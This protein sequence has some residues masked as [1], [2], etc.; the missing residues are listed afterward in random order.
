PQYFENPNMPALTFLNVAS[1]Q[2]SFDDL[3]PFVNVDTF[4]YVPQQPFWVEDLTVEEGDSIRMVRIDP[5]ITNNTYI[6]YKNGVAIDTTNSPWLTNAQYADV[7]EYHFE[8]TNV[9]LPLLTL[10]CDPFQ[11]SVV[12]PSPGQSQVS[13]N[14][15]ISI[16]AGPDPVWVVMSNDLAAIPPTLGYQYAFADSVGNILRLFNSDSVDVSSADPG[17]FRVY[18]VAVMLPSPLQVGDNLITYAD[19]SNALTRSSNYLPVEVS[20]SSSVDQALLSPLTLSPNPASD[21][22]NWSLPV[23]QGN[24]WEI[25]ILDL[26]G[27]VLWQEQSATPEGQLEVDHYPTGMYLFQVLNGTQSWTRRWVKTAR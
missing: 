22:L 19:T 4:T 8:V 20:G 17:L 3:L 25:R 11:L 24:G 10:T 5:T 13:P 7:G 15:P 23:D 12:A 1:T 9:G 21:L 6:W 16:A 2:F 18:G 26:R 27:K 14:A